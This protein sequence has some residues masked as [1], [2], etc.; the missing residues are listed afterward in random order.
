MNEPTK[1]RIKL[2]QSALLSTGFTLVIY[3]RSEV[4]VHRFAP[5]QTLSA[6]CT[7]DFT[8]HWQLVTRPKEIQPT[9]TIENWGPFQHRFQ[10]NLTS[11]TNQPD[12]K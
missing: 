12:G 5:K 4:N 9:L 6:G 2:N 1:I 3:L 10:P 8:V 11:L 7:L